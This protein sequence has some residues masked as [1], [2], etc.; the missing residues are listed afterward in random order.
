MKLL[1]LNYE[2]PPLGGG[3]GQA[4]LALCRA[5]AVEPTLDVDVVTSGQESG[6]H[7]EDLSQSMRIHRVGIPKQSLHRWKRSEVLC[8][9]WRAQRYYRRLLKQNDYQLVHAFFAFP[10]A[11]LCYR[12]RHQLP[13]LVSLRGSDVPGQNARLQLEYKILGPLVFKPIWQQA[14]QL[15]ACSEGLRQRAHRFMPGADI[16]VIPNGVDLDRFAPAVASPTRT[17]LGLITVGRLSCTKRVDWLIDAVSRLIEQEHSV[18]LTVVGDGALYEP[19]REQTQRLGL[20]AH[21]TFTGRQDGKQLPALYQQND[22]Y[23]SASMQEGMSNA[24]LEAMASGLPI[25]TTTCEGVV[26]LVDGNG[27]VVEDESVAG[28]TAAIRQLIQDPRQRQS[29]ARLA[30]ERAKQFRWEVSARQYLQCYQ[31]ILK[32]DQA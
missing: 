6:I 5:L 18:H 20:A 12:S 4:H 24:M 3:A 29:M 19:L 14:T 30:R 16:A 25:V 27:I 22:V 26:E 13:Y 10:S 17:S 9:L 1:M 7:I 15:V 32:G 11:W 21:V 28:L 8:W 23:F 31:L 2:F